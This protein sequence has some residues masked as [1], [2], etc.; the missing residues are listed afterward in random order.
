MKDG[1]AGRKRYLPDKKLYH[2]TVKLSEKEADIL[3]RDA[4]VFGKDKSKYVRH[5]IMSGGKADAAFVTDRAN[6]IRQISGVA[7]NINQ[8][9]KQANTTKVVSG[10][11]MEEIRELLRE[12]RELLTEVLKLWQSQRLSA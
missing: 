11:Q 9:A 10:Y 4:M 8:I 12:N 2:L 5:L 6:L 1:L 7:N 3:E